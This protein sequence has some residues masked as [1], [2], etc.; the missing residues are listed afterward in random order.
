MLYSLLHILLDDGGQALAEQSD[1]LQ[2]KMLLLYYFLLDAQ[3]HAERYH[4]N[5]S[6]SSSSQ[7]MA[8]DFARAFGINLQYQRVLRGLWLLDSIAAPSATPTASTHRMEED[9]KAAPADNHSSS[10]SGG[11]SVRVTEAIEC[12]V[13]SA[14]LVR[15][16]W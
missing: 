14:E 15:A 4:H 8:G 10:S 1:N 6:S 5:S 7:T 16:E 12:F 11:V 13:E 2:Q 9:S 3:A